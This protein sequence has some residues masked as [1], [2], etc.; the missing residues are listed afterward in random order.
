MKLECLGRAS[1]LYGNLCSKKAKSEEDFFFAPWFPNISGHGFQ[2]NF[3]WSAG[4]L[5]DK[6]S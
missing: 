1:K 5:V 2:E 4:E 3:V 6:Q